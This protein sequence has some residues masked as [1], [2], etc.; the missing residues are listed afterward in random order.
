MSTET[1]QFPYLLKE[2]TEAINNIKAGVEQGRADLQNVIAI[3]AQIKIL[4]PDNFSELCEAIQNPKQFFSHQLESTPFK[5][6]AFLQACMFAKSATKKKY[7]DL[8]N[9]KI[10]ILKNEVEKDCEKHRK[11][12]KDEGE[13]L[14][15]QD[16]KVLARMFHN[17]QW[18]YNNHGITGMNEIQGKALSRIY[19][20]KTDA[21]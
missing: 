1:K 16:A 9:G 5:T 11:Y 15:M 3:A 12:V 7:F 17:A 6:D 2:N 19:H 20:L 14:A 21:A 10:S 4:L 18:W 13:E 8:V